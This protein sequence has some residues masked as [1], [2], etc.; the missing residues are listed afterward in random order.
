L[1]KLQD[2]GHNVGTDVVESGEYLHQELKEAGENIQG[3][4]SPT[5]GDVDEGWASEGSA[6]SAQGSPTGLKKTRS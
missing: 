5:E 4:V 6:S 1:D 3:V 2:I